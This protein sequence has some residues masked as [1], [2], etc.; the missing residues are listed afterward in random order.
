MP[1]GPFADFRR[2]SPKFCE[3]FGYRLQWDTQWDRS[4]ASPVSQSDPTLRVKWT[5][6]HECQDS[7]SAEITQVQ[8][9]SLGT[10]RRTISGGSA[11]PEAEILGARAQ[12]LEP[13]A[14]SKS[15]R[16]KGALSRRAGSMIAAATR[17]STPC[18]A[19]PRMR[20]GNRI[21]HTN[22]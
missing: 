1:V 13:R 4:R 11:A 17:A 3:E 22:G 6:T 15:Y 20:N 18:T 19:I 14:C 8:G 9:S 7:P 16:R 2:K 12:Q 5:L 10:S 21:S